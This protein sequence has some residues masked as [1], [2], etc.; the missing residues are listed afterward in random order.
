MEIK[1]TDNG[2]EYDG[3]IF[4]DERSALLTK[5]ATEGGQSS[6]VGSLPE[7]KGFKLVYDGE[8]QRSFGKFVEKI[9]KAQNKSIVQLASDFDVSR[10]TLFAWMN[11]DSVPTR[12]NLEIIIDVTQCRINDVKLALRD[13]FKM[14]KVK[15]FEGLE[16]ARRA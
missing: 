10:Q 7:A 4:K 6:K 12:K 15:L 5:E 11:G 1:K 14:Q 13:N 8:R 3:I 2:W 9:L 16:E